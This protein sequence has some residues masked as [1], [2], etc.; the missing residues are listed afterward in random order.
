MKLKAE[1]IKLWLAEV[2]RER[3]DET[4]DSELMD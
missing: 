1:P 4:L 2:G 3:I